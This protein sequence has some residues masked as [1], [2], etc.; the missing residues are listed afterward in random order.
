MLNGVDDLL[1]ENVLAEKTILGIKGGI[2]NNGTTGGVIS[3][4]NGSVRIPE[5][6]TTGGTVSLSGVEDLNPE[7]LLVGKTVLGV[8]GKIPN[9]GETGGLIGSKTGRVFIPEGY[10]TGGTVSLTNVDDLEPEN[11]IS[12][13][14]VLGVEGKIPNNGQTGGFI[15]TK[16]GTITIPEGY[17]TGGTVALQGVDDLDPSSVIAGKTIL[18]IAG[19]AILPVVNQD[20]ESKVLYIS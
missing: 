4:K 15:N 18:G 11:L 5:G 3:A 7:N 16:N 1:P 12:G 6:Y 8:S 2:P 13:K 17:T 20:S 9:N 10:T 14:S 19:E